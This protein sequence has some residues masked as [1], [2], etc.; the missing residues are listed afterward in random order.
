M[1]LVSN[2]LRCLKDS[3]VDR[4]SSSAKLR[5]AWNFLRGSK[6]MYWWMCALA[7]MMQFAAFG[8]AL[9]AGVGASRRVPSSMAGDELAFAMIVAGA[10]GALYCHFTSRRF[11]WLWRQPKPRPVEPL[12]F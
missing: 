1:I 10:S 11:Y 8:M 4:A 7:F 6:D 5:L 3:L 9:A 12:P 2:S